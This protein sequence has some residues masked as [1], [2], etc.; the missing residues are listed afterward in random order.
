M[1]WY[2]LFTRTGQE[3]NIKTHLAKLLD[4]DLSMPF[5][6]ILE[7]LFK[8]KGLVKKEY[9]PLFPG[10]VFI[11][12]VLPSM[13]FLNCINK[14]IHSFED[15]F[16][17]LK[18]GDS[19]EIA[20]QEHEKNMLLR[21]SNDNHCIESSSG[22]IVGN[23][24]Y[25]NDGPLKGFESIIKKIDRH[26]RQAIIELEFMGELRCITLALEILSKI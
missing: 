7:T 21:L 3:E 22:F 12:S 19:N 26:K 4:A 17:I 25:I 6:P 24:V 5:I 20:L 13:D 16:K 8:T 23:K 10:Y 9:Q 14:I 11:E 2:I 15:I 18:Y 1:Y